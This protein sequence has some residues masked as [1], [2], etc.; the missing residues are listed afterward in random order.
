MPH[1]PPKEEAP[2]LKGTRYEF[3]FIA[4]ALKHG[5]H[6]FIPAGDY[7]PV[8]G[9]VMN[10]SG[11]MFRVQVRGTHGVR[12]QDKKGSRAASV[13]MKVGGYLASGTPNLLKPT[14]Y[15]VLAA[16]IED[17]SMWYIIPSAA[18]GSTWKAKFYPHVEKSKGQYEKFQEN[19]DLFLY[20]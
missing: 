8:D 9:I 13:S 7:L 18:I 15:D 14:E 10:N 4:T 2:K 19:W 3:L 5:L 16:F 17:R 12:V 6:V 11:R 1:C 20:Q